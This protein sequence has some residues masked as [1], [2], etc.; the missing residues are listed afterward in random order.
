MAE[1]NSGIAFAFRHCW[2]KLQYKMK[3]H[4]ADELCCPTSSQK[5]V[6]AWNC[7]EMDGFYES[8]LGQ[9]DKDKTQFCFNTQI[10]FYL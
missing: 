3:D 4:Q 2:Q 5:A 1:L 7:N 10:N 8:E 9:Y 6:D